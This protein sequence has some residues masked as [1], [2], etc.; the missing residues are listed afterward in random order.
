MPS[1]LF[2]HPRKTQGTS[3]IS[4]H[5]EVTFA[6]DSKQASGWDSAVKFIYRRG[7]RERPQRPQRTAE[8]SWN[9]V[10]RKSGSRTNGLDLCETRERVQ[11]AQIATLPVRSRYSS[12]DL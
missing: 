4:V 12:P 2:L 5:L 10:S 8:S 9:E 7:H 6:A 1:G 3:K 11:P